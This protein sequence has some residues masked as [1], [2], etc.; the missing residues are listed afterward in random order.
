MAVSW[1]VLVPIAAHFCCLFD[2]AFFS[3]FAGL[4]L[5]TQTSM[6]GILRRFLSISSTAA[7]F[8]LNSIIGPECYGEWTLADSLALSLVCHLTSL[9]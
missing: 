2:V 4:V 5:A 8:S 1:I 9:S 6:P 3:T 7:S